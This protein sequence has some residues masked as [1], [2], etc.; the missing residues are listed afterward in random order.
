MVTTIAYEEMHIK[1][2]ARKNVDKLQKYL[3]QNKETLEVLERDTDTY[4]TP[5]EWWN[6][7]FEDK[8][9]VSSEKFL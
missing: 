6:K 2:Y 9:P 8:S 4:Y 1:A 7:Q 5:A 3:K